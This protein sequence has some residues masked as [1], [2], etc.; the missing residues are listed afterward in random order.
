M[1]AYT[2]G[3]VEQDSL[4]CAGTMA[5]HCLK[6]VFLWSLYVWLWKATVMTGK[7]DL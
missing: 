5:W 2:G 3:M 6:Y 1:A 7:Q 4:A